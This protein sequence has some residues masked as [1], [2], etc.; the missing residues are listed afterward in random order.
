MRTSPWTRTSGE[1][2]S[3]SPSGG[4]DRVEVEIEVDRHPVAERAGSRDLGRGQRQAEGLQSDRPVVER[5]F[6][7]EPG[8]HAGGPELECPCHEGKVV[9]D[10]HNG[11]DNGPQHRGEKPCRADTSAHVQAA[12]AGDRLVDRDEAHIDDVDI[13]VGRGRRPP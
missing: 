8:P 5:R 13:G 6:A 12:P 10:H 4:S 1:N 11:I 3:A 9:V 2:E 7:A